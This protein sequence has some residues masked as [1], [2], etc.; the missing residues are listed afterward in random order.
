MDQGHTKPLIC[1]D[2][3]YGRVYKLPRDE[4]GVDGP[5]VASVTT[6]TAHGLPMNRWLFKW[7][8]ET[9]KGSWDNYIAFNGAASEIGTKVHEL[10]DRMLHGEEIAISDDPAMYLAGDGII[11]P[12]SS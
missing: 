9:S 1:A 7:H 5:Y 3:T 2:S 12:S 11:Q 6:I 4:K 8:L 10:F